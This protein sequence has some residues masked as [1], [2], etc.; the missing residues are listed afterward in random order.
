MELASEIREKL[1]KLLQKWSKNPKNE[2]EATFGEG[3]QVSMTTFL[4]IGKRLQS[5]SMFEQPILSEYLNI[6]VKNGP[7]ITL[8][9]LADIQDYCTTDSL[10]NK[11]FVVLQKRRDFD[12]DADDVK[13][14]DYDVKCKIREE[15]TK[16]SKD[17]SVQK[18]LMK[19]AEQDK[20]FRLI[21]RWT[22]KSNGFQ[23]DMSIVRST[24][25]VKTNDGK[26]TFL[27]QKLFRDQDVALEK[28]TYEVEIELHHDVDTTKTPELAL[29]T[30][31]KGIGE[32]LRGIQKNTLLLRKS[33]KQAVLAGY[34]S[35]TK[36]SG[37]IGSS[38]ATLELQNMALQLKS[39]TPNI[40][41]GYNVT[42]KADGLRVLAYCNDDG[43]MFLIDMGMNVYKTALKKEACKN[44]LLDGEWVTSTKEGKATNALLLF[45]IYFG[46]NKTNVSSLP[47]YSSLEQTQT[48][49]AAL[50]AWETAWSI[51]INSIE[52]ARQKKEGAGGA[53]K[54]LLLYL[55]VSVKKFE[56]APAGSNEIFTKAKII[57]SYAQNQFYNT[58]GLIFTPND[59]PLPEY[60]NKEGGRISFPQQFKW[61]PAKD[62]SIDFLVK[63]IK[64]EDDPTQDEVVDGT[65]PETR[66]PVRYKIFRL[67]VRSP[68]DA[69]WNDPRETILYE[70]GIPK[71]TKTFSAVPFNPIDYPDEYASYCY[72]ECK[73]DDI[74]EIDVSY[75]ESNEPITNNSIVEMRYD[76]AAADGWRWIPMRIRSDKTENLL[77]VPR[78]SGKGAVKEGLNLE[79]SLNADRTAQN[80]WNSIHNPITYG[81]ITT[82]SELPTKEEQEEEQKLLRDTN[83]Y[84]K[85]TVTKGRDPLLK[86]MLTFHNIYIK[87]QILLRSTLRTPGK[88]ILDVSVGQG[89]DIH[90]WVSYNIAFALGTDKAA[91]GIKNRENGAY[92]RYLQMLAHPEGRTIP[93]M[94]FAIADSSKDFVSGTA[95]DVDGQPTVDSAILR[96]VF[97]KVEATEDAPPYVRQDTIQGQLAGGA[98]LVSCMFTLHY[99]FESKAVFEGFRNNLANCLKVGGY[100][101]ACYFDGDRVFDLLARTEK[102]EFQEGRLKNEFLWRI[103][104]EYESDM[105]PTDDTAFG[106]PIKVDFRTI[107]AAHTEYLVP[108]SLLVSEMKK[109]GCALITNPKELAAMQIKASSQFFETSYEM[110]RK[111][112]KN[113]PM[114]TALQQF[115]FLN[116][117][118]IFRRYKTD[119]IVDNDPLELLQSLGDRPGVDEVEAAQ[120]LRTAAPVSET[121]GTDE[122]KVAEALISAT[123]PSESGRLA[124]ESA[125][126]AKRSNSAAMR[127]VPISATAPSTPILPIVA[128]TAA[129]GQELAKTIREGT[130]G[131]VKPQAE[132]EAFVS[133]LV[134]AAPRIFPLAKLFTFSDQG[135]LT[136]DPLKLKDKNKL[137]DIA[138]K[139]YPLPYVRVPG[140]IPD[141]SNPDALYPT[142]DHYMAAM[143]Y[144][145]ATNMLTIKGKENFA[146]DIFGLEKGQ[147]GNVGSLE[148]KYREEFERIKPLNSK[149]KINQKELYTL[150]KTIANE[151]HSMS[152]PQRIKDFGFQFDDSKWLAKKNEVLAYA[153]RK[154]FEADDDLKTILY[155]ARA[156]DKYVLY[157]LEKGVVNELGGELARAGKD[158]QVVGDNKLGTLYM[159]LAA[160]VPTKK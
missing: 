33:V 74:A 70:K 56:F 88:K 127:T 17:A 108:F 32:I 76:R 31:I 55:A 69:R 84:Y 150:L 133:A 25:K 58:D 138:T 95:A 109:I 72:V 103:T 157:Q 140:M 96:A 131:V 43:E 18:Y 92:A 54:A 156:L 73:R 151:V 42:D 39:N 53:P 15:I 38:P 120:I 51:P 91:G 130:V 30:F 90:R 114:D 6:I 4:N 155:E 37:F 27:W 50:K 1:A 104:K 121:A 9:N 139:R 142:I 87:E 65:H 26:H 97:G 154:R 61:K 52:S 28:P 36:S 118:V 20:A 82:G 148:L 105:L 136:D 116:R 60:L 48:R 99:F 7:R 66:A 146:R 145:I 111:E 59:T 71:D 24:K 101:V 81:M 158:V 128:Q 123:S 68:K 80:T 62:N 122:E 115:S 132:G 41:S 153:V 3:G 63:T 124:V 47:F 117:W 126:A 46:L 5:K 8:T 147:T 89:S 19:W 29:A 12:K 100:F 21:R 2:L 64:K 113:Y 93:P 94:V 79:S 83:E 85:H 49:Y 13:L 119:P 159:Q 10:E 57:L 112:G 35:L 40:R 107:G 129:K 144:K 14:D 11:D 75:T 77:T 34:T 102:G 149:K 135:S 45:D 106:M 22:F 160:E 16:D 23:I 141:E 67:L 44:T 98:D 134:Q 78:H 152:T 143:K 110:E 86:G 125:A 137:K